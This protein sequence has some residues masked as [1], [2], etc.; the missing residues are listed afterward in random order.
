MV[1]RRP[2]SALQ[3]LAVPLLA[4]AMLVTAWP[5]SAQMAS[6]S[7]TSAWMRPARAGQDNARA[8]VDIASDV[9]LTLTQAT[10]PDARTV[11]IVR[12]APGGSAADE[13]VVATMP[14]AP[15]TPTRL[16]FR[17]SHLRLVGILRDLGNGD[18]VPVTLHF[19]DSDGRVIRASIDVSVR[20][21]TVPAA[22]PDR[23]PP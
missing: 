20:G 5:A 8:Y 10:T 9:P 7:L 14:V 16:A 4:V 15:G 21:F 3:H 19:A 11:E 22:A 23:R 13:A 12:V 1:A 17:G 6:I 2:R 18:H